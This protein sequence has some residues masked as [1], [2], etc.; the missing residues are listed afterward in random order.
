MREKWRE[1]WRWARQ[2]R[3]LNYLQAVQDQLDWAAE[4]LL[5]ARE[6]N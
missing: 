5:N 4:R 6:A 3:R 2:K 1:A